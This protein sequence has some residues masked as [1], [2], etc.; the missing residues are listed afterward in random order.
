MAVLKRYQT[1][2]GGREFG[3]HMGAREA[4][5]LN[6][7]AGIRTQSNAS[8]IE[9]LV[10]RV[11]TQQGPSCTGACG[12]YWGIATPVVSSYTDLDVVKLY[13]LEKQIDGDLEEG[14]TIHTL[15]KA[16]GPKYGGY[17]CWERLRAAAFAWDLMTVDDFMLSGQGGVMFGMPWFEGMMKVDALGY[18]HPTGKM[19]GGHAVFCYGTN[20]IEGSRS[21]MQS[22]GLIPEFPVGR[23][24]ITDKEMEYLWGLG[25]EAAAAVELPLPVDVEPQPIVPNGDGCLALLKLFG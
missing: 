21:F 12:C 9:Y 23:F 3:W 7:R 2:F 20:R 5:D 24:K 18:V 22:W 15:V 6:L 19:V 16:L 14:S 17:A 10:N 8:Q 13:Q 4:D 25:C 11:L 1:S